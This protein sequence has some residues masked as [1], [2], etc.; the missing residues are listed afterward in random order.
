MILL[1]PLI[2]Y[3]KNSLEKFSRKEILNKL[4]LDNRLNNK[5]KKEIVSEVQFVEETIKIY[6]PFLFS[7]MTFT[8]SR[9]S[10]LFPNTEFRLSR[11]KK[12]A[13]IEMLLGWIFI[14]IIIYIISRVVII[15][16]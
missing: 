6:D 9:V 15:A 3:R 7:L 13:T 11:N 5:G 10:S 14:S 16:I 12:C 8:S 2:F 4:P 1:F